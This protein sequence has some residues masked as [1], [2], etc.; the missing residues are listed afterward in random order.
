MFDQQSSG[1]MLLLNNK[2]TKIVIS[3]ILAGGVGCFLFLILLPPSQASN[4]SASLIVYPEG[5]SKV[6]GNIPEFDSGV[7]MASGCSEGPVKLFAHNRDQQHP[8]VAYNPIENSY[9]VV[10][11]DNRTGNFDIYGVIMPEGC[12][13]PA[14]AGIIPI[15][16]DSSTG[17]GQ[18]NV[19]QTLP[20]VVYNPDQNKYFVIWHDAET[21]VWGRRISSKGQLEGNPVKYF[22]HLP[23][24]V[25]TNSIVT[26]DAREDAQYLLVSQKVDTRDGQSTIRLRRIQASDLKDL[27]S[28]DL[29]PAANRQQLGGV[30]RNSLAGTNLTVWA[31]LDPDETDFEVYAQGFDGEGARIGQE[32]PISIAPYDQV[33]PAIA[34]NQQCDAYLIVWEDAR[35]SDESSGSDI[36]RQSVPGI[37]T[38]PLPLQLPI[39]RTLTQTERNPDITARLTQMEYLV[40]WQAQNAG[41]AYSNIY[42]QR[43]DCAGMPLSGQNLVQVSNMNQ[44]QLS[45][46]VAY[47]ARE[48]KYLIVWSGKTSDTGFDIFA[49][50]LDTNLIDIIPPRVID[51]TPEHGETDIP[52]SLPTI[53]I[54][55]SEA[56]STATVSI[57]TTPAIAISGPP[58]WGEDEQSVTFKVGSRLGFSQNYTVEVT[59]EDR[60]GN[61]IEVK[62][63]ENPWSFTT[64]TRPSFA[65]FLPIIMQCYPFIGLKN[66]DFESD[67]SY[68]IEKEVNG[69]LVDLI[70]SNDGY[71]YADFGNNTC[72]VRLGNPALGSGDPKKKDIPNGH[73]TISQQITIPCSGSPVLKFDYYYCSYDIVEWRKGELRDSLEISLDSVVISRMGF[74]ST[75]P[76]PPPNQ[77]RCEIGSRAIPLSGYSGQGVDLAFTIWNRE[78]GQIDQGNGYRKTWAYIDNIRIE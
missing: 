59:G 27:F 37:P 48:E 65:S 40:A 32:I 61:D 42:A 74:P 73:A 29:S 47:L 2:F 53:T 23:G 4:L 39:R 58:S 69:H 75:Y 43:V 67:L 22:S 36:F 52:V 68:W 20:D 7:T 24:G 21:G 9:L 3:L 8:R 56:M 6:L 66:G 11:E 25:Y 13:Y 38:L 28:G 16:E 1:K 35:N 62:P 41:E 54:R 77:L 26:Y 34:F 76:T 63:G 55:F 78:P 17:S 71:G 5:G 57:S 45:P 72:V 19:D 31:E 44:E 15:F 49:D 50:L 51:S 14:S 60:A 30:A 18:K 10:W 64:T 46:V 12:P 33:S 70:C